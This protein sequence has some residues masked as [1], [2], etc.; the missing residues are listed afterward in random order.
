MSAARDSFRALF[1]ALDEASAAEL[2][3]RLDA[4]R[5]EN[6][7]EAAAWLASYPLGDDTTDWA[8][9]RGDAIA[10]AVGI[11]RN[12]DPSKPDA[13][14]DF[15]QP[16]RTYLYTRLRWKFRCDAVTTHPDT[17]KRVAVGYSHFGH[18][19]WQTGDLSEGIWADGGWTDV[20]EAGTR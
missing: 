12:P 16:G 1:G 10:W 7:E 11:L 18:G 14:P 19:G 8:R 6:R 5:V 17:S 13:A 3:R 2:D 15:F 9:G 20:T 4:H